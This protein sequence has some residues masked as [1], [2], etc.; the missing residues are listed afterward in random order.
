MY[1]SRTID[2]K[3]EQW[4]LD[5]TLK[6]LMLRGA[7]QVGKSS[8]VKN[9]A[10]QF[11]YF[12]EINLDEMPEYAVIFENNKDVN[13]ICKVISALSNTPIV[14][15][16]TLLFIDEIQ[17]ST[18]AIGSLRYFYEKRPSLHVISA[19]SLLE[20]ALENLPS[21]GVGRVRSLFV[22]PFS[23]KEFLSAHDETILL[24]VLEKANEKT[25]LLEPI[26]QKLK[27]YY[28]AFLIVG[29]M[30]EAVKQYLLSNDFIKTQQVLDDLIVS[31]QADFA[32]YKNKV[33]NARIK[34]VFN[35]VVNQMGNK[36]SYSVGFNSLTN[37]QIK[38]ALE[39]LKMAGLIIPIVHSACNGIPLGAQV[40]L[41]YQKYLIFDTGI[42]QRLLGLNLSEYL[43]GD[44]F[45][46]INKGAIAELSVGLEIIKN[47]SPFQSHALFYWQRDAK[48]SLAEVDYVIQK[49]EMIIPI[50]VKAGTKGTMQSMFLFLKEKQRNYGI[51]FSLENFG[52]L[53]QVKIY[54][55]YAVSNFLEK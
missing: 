26:H 54:P 50:E 23:F 15:G 47:S 10:K 24:D 38:E 35:A 45:E 44:N 52:E 55:L 37:L 48:N 17:V 20:F 11:K 25:P 12:I 27:N 28:K 34:E 18:A 32:K 36:F 49:N 30:P 39:L 9:L 6:P 8:A 5:R 13:E 31:M 53:A 29:G 14:D 19:G 3:L 4:R 7:R 51:R 46:M 22:Y 33:P 16:E 40:N 42:F 43:L 41:K 21:F 2:L 1:Y